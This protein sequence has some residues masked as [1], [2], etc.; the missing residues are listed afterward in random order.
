MLLLKLTHQIFYQLCSKF[1][2]NFLDRY[3]F[4]Y[5]DMYKI[6]IHHVLQMK[7]VIIGQCLY[8]VLSLYMRWF[9]YRQ[10]NFPII[11]IRYG[12]FV[13]QK[14]KVILWFDIYFFFVIFLYTNQQ[15]NRHLSVYIPFSYSFAYYSE[16]NSMI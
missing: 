12:F 15:T 16:F 7:K 2:W 9:R 14:K 6:Y 4:E 10:T 3:L 8:R 5:I 13:F 11:K 1:I